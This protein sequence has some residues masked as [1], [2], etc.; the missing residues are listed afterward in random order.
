M[1]IDTATFVAAMSAVIAALSALVSVW[2]QA[3]AHL[4]V[5]GR[6]CIVASRGGEQRKVNRPSVG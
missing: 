1:D 4:P 3:D 5:T 2:S 6:N